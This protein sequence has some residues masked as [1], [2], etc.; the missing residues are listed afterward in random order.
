MFGTHDAD[1]SDVTQLP[2]HHTGPTRITLNRGWLVAAIMLTTALVSRWVA[3][4]VVD[5]VL[6][7]MSSGVALLVETAVV[8]ALYGLVAWKLLVQPLQ[9]RRMLTRIPVRVKP[10]VVETPRRHLTLVSS[11]GRVTSAATGTR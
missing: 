8:A 2:H 10:A 9:R 5:R 4:T 6:P 7:P 11:T 1:T 3:T